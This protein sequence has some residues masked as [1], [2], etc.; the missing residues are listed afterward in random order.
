M[1]APGPDGQPG[2]PGPDIR[3]RLRRALTEA[4]KAR[5]AGA[6]SALRSALGAI[7]NAEAVDLGEAGPARP[8]VSGSIHFAG[9]AAGLGAAE[10]ERRHLTEAD[11]IAIVRA[12]AAEREAAASRYERHGLDGQ[13]AELRHGTRALMDA[14]AGSDG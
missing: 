8:G 10:A 9:A 1:R 11:V 13:A 2:D 7:G 3:S 5:D 4:I 12:E 6:V 14:L